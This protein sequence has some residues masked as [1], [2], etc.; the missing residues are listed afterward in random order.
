MSRCEK[1]FSP[2]HGIKCQSMTC[3]RNRQAEEAR[4]AVRGTCGK[5]GVKDF[6]ERWPSH[7]APLDA[8]IYADDPSKNRNVRYDA[9]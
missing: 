2:F 1:C 6:G 7:E 9:R 3:V 4:D 5:V 8:M